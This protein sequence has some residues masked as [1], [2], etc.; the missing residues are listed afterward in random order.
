MLIYGSEIRPI[1][2]I[3]MKST[4]A[5]IALIKCVFKVWQ[6]WHTIYYVPLSRED[7]WWISCYKKEQPIVSLTYYVLQAYKCPLIW[8]RLFSVYFQIIMKHFALS[9]SLSFAIFLSCTY[10]NCICLP[11][12]NRRWIFCD[13]EIAPHCKRF[14]SLMF[15]K[16]FF[17]PVLGFSFILRW[18]KT[19]NWSL[20]DFI[21]F[22]RIFPFSSSKMK[23]WVESRDR[24]FDFEFPKK[25]VALSEISFSLLD[26]SLW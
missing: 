3:W 17:K 15:R 14:E 8:M 4:L 25:R 11:N 21:Q 19:K 5:F 26:I 12:W 1:I 9:F 18:V 16:V 7:G 2:L 23:F 6:S 10:R 22:D 24:I 13:V 20:W